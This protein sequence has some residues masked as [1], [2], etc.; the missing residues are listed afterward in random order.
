MQQRIVRE[1]IS[2]ARKWLMV[3]EDVS[4]VALHDNGYADVDLPGLE[5]WAKKKSM[6]P[7]RRNYN[8][9]PVTIRKKWL[10]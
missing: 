7:C 9:V 10:I 2:I 5:Q 3:S 6:R 8:S 1:S 4:V